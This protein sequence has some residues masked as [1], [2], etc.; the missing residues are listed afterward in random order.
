MMNCK[1][2]I[3]IALLA[4]NAG[5]YAQDLQF[6]QSHPEHRE[7]ISV[8]TGLDFGTSFGAAYAYRLPIAIPA[9]AGL[10]YSVYYGKKLFDDSKTNLNLQAEVLRRGNFGV[11][12]QAGMLMRRYNSDL[13]R[14]FNL[15]A[16]GKVAAGL[17]RSKW[18][19]AAATAYDKPM[20][21]KIHQK[22]L[23]DDYPGI[24]DGWFRAPGGSFKF[25]LETGFRFH[26][27]GLH[28]QLGRISGQNFR[29]N[30]TVPYY[31]NVLLAKTW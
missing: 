6:F 19:L 2:L 7:M 21:T 30:P 5:L 10:E 8:Q 24:Q 23:R 20:A 9:A 13:A 26:S 11:H 15:G 29:N 25:G 27:Y 1:Y 4:C 28:L 14:L 12:A 18:Y 3:F 31:F 22:G 17:Y 16:F